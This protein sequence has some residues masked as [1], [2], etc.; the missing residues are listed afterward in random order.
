MQKMHITPEE[1]M[2]IQILIRE[3]KERYQSSED[4]DFLQNAA[5]FAHELPKTVRAFLHEFK[6]NEPDLGACLLSGYVVDPQKIGKTP[7]HWNVRPSPSPTIEEEIFLILCG[8]LLGEPFGWST[9]QNGYVVNNVVP[10]KEHETDQLGS[11]SKETLI[12]HTED[13]QHPYRGDYLAL[14]CLRNPNQAPTLYAPFSRGY[15][16]D[17]QIQTLFES[18]FI[19]YPDQGHAPLNRYTDEQEHVDASLLEVAYQ[20]VAELT[21]NPQKEAVLFGNPHYPYLRIDPTCM[22]DITDDKAAH[23]ALV[24]L[25]KSIDEN[26]QEVALQP[27]DICFLDNNKAVHGRK[28]FQAYYDGNDRWLKRIN[29][30]RDL[31]KSIASRPDKR[32]RVVS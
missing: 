26:I 5:L 29:I 24:A 14:F 30:T 27:G 21:T 4:L 23:E 28:A 9:Q 20:K 15:L 12:W 1:N 18:R 8:N 7:P 2:S 31:K 13:Y 22:G 16:S 17:A 25:M 32:S 3:I 19:M 10:I 11:G 6:Q